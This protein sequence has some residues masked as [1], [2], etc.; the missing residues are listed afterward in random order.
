MFHDPRDSMPGSRESP[1]E[2]LD[3]PPSRAS[4]A[5]MELPHIPRRMPDP[6]RAHGAWVYLIV[7][8]LAGALTSIGQGCSGHDGITT[9][10]EID[11]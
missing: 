11:R 3:S 10:E 8:I 6:A 9:H 7:S 1:R 5:P 2:G 4:E